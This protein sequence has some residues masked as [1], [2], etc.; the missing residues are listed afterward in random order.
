MCKRSALS[1]ATLRF[2]LALGVRRR[3]A[4]KVAK[5]A[6]AHTHNLALAVMCKRTHLHAHV[7][8][9]GGSG[10]H[11]RPDFLFSDFEKWLGNGGSSRQLM[12]LFDLSSK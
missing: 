3:H 6:H 12:E 1:D 10:S 2:D 9:F 4:P 7:H 5:N 8:A 11:G